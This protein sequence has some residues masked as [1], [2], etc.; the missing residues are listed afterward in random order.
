MKILWPVLLAFGLNTAAYALTNSTPAL[1]TQWMNVL[2]IASSAP[3]SKGEKIAGYC[4]ATLI[5]K[6]VLITAAHCV[7]LAYLSGMKTIEI[8]VGHYKSVTRKFDGQTVRIGYVPKFK[9]TKI[10]NIELPNSLIDKLQIRGE[11]E[12]ISPKEDV[13]LL[14]WNGESL[15]LNNVP[16]A[17]IIGPNEHA[18]ILKNFSQASFTSVTINK[19][20]NMSLDTKRISLLNDFSWRNYINSRSYSRVEE[21]D[22]G[23]PLFVTVAGKYKV[24]AVVKGRGSTI[25][26]NWDAFTAINP[27]VCQ[28][29]KNLPTSIQIPACK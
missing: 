1:S 21:G 2:Q 14:W 22:S 12:S 9:L 27:H 28:L 5:H 24:F 10:V 20:A 23:A 7:K 16:V 15:E 26:S 29:A 11:K 3:D 17:E 4:N 19:I 8:E 25:F 18:A 6:N 13:A